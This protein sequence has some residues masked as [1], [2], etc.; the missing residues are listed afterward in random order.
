MKHW[1][2][3]TADGQKVW[4]RIDEEA[5]TFRSTLQKV[6]PDWKDVERRVTFSDE[7]GEKIEDLIV[8]SDHTRPQL[9]RYIP[10]GAV[11]TRTEFYVRRDKQGGSSSSGT[12]R[13]QLAESETERATASGTGS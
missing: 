3:K 7:T 13:E 6:G 12:L 9:Y 10:G 8:R 11:K 5:K 2:A 4:T 1:W